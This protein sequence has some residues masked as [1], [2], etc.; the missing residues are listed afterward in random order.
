MT[1]STPLENIIA[2]AKA[3]N[4]ADY[5]PESWAAA[6][7][8][9]AN[10]LEECEEMLANI[11]N[12]TTY[13]VEEQIGHL[14]EALNMLVK[15]PAPTATPAQRLQHQPRHSQPQHRPLHSQ[16]Q[17]LH[18][19]QHRPKELQQLQKLP[20]FIPKENLLQPLRL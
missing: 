11:K 14:R 12:Q 4:E 17:L 6:K 18:R 9:I 8:S 3:L 20:Q 2:E 7:D 13:G 16:L 10:E 15:A 5:T 1:D 19:L